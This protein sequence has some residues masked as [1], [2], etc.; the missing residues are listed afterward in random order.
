MSDTTDRMGRLAFLRI[1]DETRSE[2]RSFQPAIEAALP[3]IL[4]AFYE[5]LGRYPDLTR[6][7]A[8]KDMAHAR[9]LQHKHWLNLFS[10][11][12]DDDYVQ[13]VRRIGA[14]HS[15]IGLAPRWYIGAYAFMFEK[16]LAVATKAT[17]GRLHPTADGARL[18]RL[19][20]ALAVAVMLDMDFAISIYL[21]EN[22][23]RHRNRLSAISDE[24]SGSIQ[25]IV[26]GVA[27]A[28]TEMHGS[29]ES[30][31]AIAEETG[32]QAI[33]VET[34][35][36]QASANVQTVA[37]AAEQLTAS[38]TEIARQIVESAQVAGQAVQQAERANETVQR[39]TEGAQRIGEVVTL[40]NGIASQ[41]NLLAL[42]ATIE[43]ARAG[44]AGKGFAVVANEVKTL[45]TQT[46]K[47]TDDIRN[48]I[49]RIQVSSSDAAG[50][51]QTIGD[52]IRRI[53]AITGMVA[54]AVEQQGAATAEIARNVQ[55]AANGTA[56]VSSN[57]AGVSKAADET[58][59]S[60]A[61]LLGA[62][63]ILGQQS[64]SLRSQ[65]HDFITRIAAA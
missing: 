40:I 42:N 61:H 53:D 52:T 26:D 50:A 12:F 51:I 46:A 57:I 16:L 7:F 18:M 58:G 65:V 3:A 32:R 19:Q 25:G 8:G 34:A 4:D 29:A 30:M 15:R 31:S 13:S 24:F 56:K 23:S 48:Q 49:S 63:E 59:A 37:A 21:E 39:L 2:L 60:A 1:D 44:E 5:Y 17:I 20:R 6:L 27:V 54:T 22:D 55:E 28:A 43:A 41:T 33:A 45:A 38:I 9:G 36:G 11:R 35:S 10:G 62:A 14:V 47:A 64:D